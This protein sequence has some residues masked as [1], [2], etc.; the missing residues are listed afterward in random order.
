M[1]LLFFIAK[2]VGRAIKAPLNDK[3]VPHKSVSRL[4]HQL[5]MKVHVLYGQGSLS[6]CLYAIQLVHVRNVSERLENPEPLWS[7]LRY[8]REAEFFLGK[9]AEM[10]CFLFGH[11]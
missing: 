7:S 1:Q 10:K 5:V 2:D 8:Y 9:L 11:S 4:M 6:N 3:H